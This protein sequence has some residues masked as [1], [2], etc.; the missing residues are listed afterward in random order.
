M[1]RATLAYLHFEALLVVLCLTFHLFFLEGG[2]SCVV[3]LSVGWWYQIHISKTGG[4]TYL[5][6]CESLPF[7]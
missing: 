2:T 5:C 4:D 6:P 7:L 1:A 3:Y